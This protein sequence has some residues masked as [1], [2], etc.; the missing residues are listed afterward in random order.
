MDATYKRVFLLVAAAAVLATFVVG[1]G[2]SGVA[3]VNGRK[4]TRQE[5]FS[6]L[7]RLQYRD[8]TTN[9]PIEAGAWVVQ[10]LISEELLLRL[11]EKEGV[12][13]S[14]QQV[15]ERTVQ[16]HKQPGFTAGVKASGI[17]PDQLK[18]LLRVEQALFNLQ[19]R[20][21]KVAD[22]EVRDFYDRNKDTSFTT[23]EQ[24]EVAAI[25][26]NS[27]AEAEEAMGLLAK[28]VDFGT[29]AARMSK[30]PNTAKQEGRLPVP[31]TRGDRNIPEYVQKAIFS[32]PKSR[33][34]NPIAYGEGGYVIFQMIQRHPKRTRRFE[35]EKYRIRQQLMVQKGIEKQINVEQELA[36]FRETA[37]IDIGIERYKKILVPE[38]AEGKK[39]EKQR[40]EGKTK[41]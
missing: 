16:A 12:A 13:P 11:A 23:P 3:K 5:Y 2:R 21:V 31:I 37:K 27:K 1:C 34:T 19:T 26:L 4:I 38:E 33:Y 35:D 10:R 32:T 29:V 20:D 41:K 7:E 24:A 18:E 39:T 40:Q 36:K 25:F 9:Q 17:T 22:K 14:D 8:P 28:K 30:E 6:R 15:R